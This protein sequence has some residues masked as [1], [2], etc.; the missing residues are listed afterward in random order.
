MIR[1][2]SP[3]DF[4][5]VLAVQRESPGAAQWSEADYRRLAEDPGGLIL[6]AD[7]SG[8]VAP[9]AEDA[10][11]P[12]P[13]H[14]AR[15]PADLSSPALAGFA[16]FH[17]VLDEAELR[18]LAVLPRYR[19]RGLGRALLDAAHQRLWQLGVKRVYL[20]V[21]AGNDPAIQLYLAAGYHPQSI[22][23]GY[24]QAPDENAC[25]LAISRTRSPEGD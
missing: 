9:A 22:R 21:R 11:E 14:E 16:A 13:D 3:H 24:Y 1:H 20:E 6:V 23:K 18:N 10:A 17:R 25:V 4:A 15:T 19:R 2:L 8:G 7:A 5:A 12:E